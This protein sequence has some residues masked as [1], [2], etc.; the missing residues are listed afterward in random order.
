MESV[1]SQGVMS[2]KTILACLIT[3]FL[4]ILLFASLSTPLTEGYFSDY[5]VNRMVSYG[6]IN[7]AVPFRD[8]FDN[9]GPVL[10]II[11]LLGTILSVGKWGVYLIESLF[12]SWTLILLCKIGEIVSNRNWRLIYISIGLTLFSMI[13]MIGGANNEEYSL[14]FVLYP[15]LIAVRHFFGHQKFTW[16]EAVL[17]GI[18]FACVSQIRLNNSA[19]IMGICLAFLYDYVRHKEFIQL[20]KLIGLFI[21]GIAIVLIPLIFYFI[22]EGSLYDMIYDSILYNIHYRSNWND[23]NPPQTTLNVLRLLSCIVLP[24]FSYLYDRKKGLHTFPLCL[25]ISIVTF[26]VFYAGVG[27]WHYYQMQLPIFFLCGIIPSFTRNR[28][29]VIVCM[30]LILPSLL[31]TYRTLVSDIDILL[32]WEGLAKTKNRELWINPEVYRI[33]IFE[34]IPE[35]ER[36]SIYLNGSLQLSSIFVGTNNYP[37]GKYFNLQSNIAKVDT[38]ASDDIW[39]SF[40][41]ANPL[42]ILSSIPL[43]KDEFWRDKPIDYHLVTEVQI[44]YLREPIF[45]Y[46]RN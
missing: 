16:E 8:L 31:T 7:G 13:P 5:L 41:E 1:K 18:C 43:E 24:V 38:E 34:F 20:G 29:N 11:H 35:S 32:H 21:V 14:P 4:Y 39:T 25:G 30:S 3:S 36:N 17:S 46:N 28:I 22:S 10:F 23:G 9:K 15:L 44:Q 42:W 26:F 12:L 37:K 40:Q 6:W 33:K 19:I 2:A 45:V 27:Y